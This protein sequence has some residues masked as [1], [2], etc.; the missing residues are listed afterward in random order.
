MP[1][2]I[3]WALEPRRKNYHF[4]V[5]DYKEGLLFSFDKYPKQCFQITKAIPFGCHGW[6]RKKTFPFWKKIILG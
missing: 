6:N 4:P 5:P 2:D 1:E 3:F